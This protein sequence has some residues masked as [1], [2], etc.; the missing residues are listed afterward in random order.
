[1]SNSKPV[2]DTSTLNTPANSDSTAFFVNETPADR[3]ATDE[4]NSDASDSLGST[5]STSL[6][7]RMKSCFNCFNY[8]ETDD[9]SLGESTPLLPTAPLR[10]ET[11]QPPASCFSRFTR[12]ISSA[13]SQVKNYLTS[14]TFPHIPELA[15][16]QW[17]LS[18]ALTVQEILPA[19]LFYNI[20]LGYSVLNA[21]S[22]FYQGINL[23][24]NAVILA[25]KIASLATVATNFL[26]DLTA[27]T[28][29]EDAVFAIR[30][31]QN[32]FKGKWSAPQNFSGSW[33]APTF[34]ALTGLILAFQQLG[35]A[36]L[37]S[38]DGIA[39]Q[40][41]L[42]SWDID[43]SEGTQSTL[44]T[45]ATV[46]F[47]IVG[48]LY[49]N[50]FVGKNV[51]SHVEALINYLSW[52]GSKLSSPIDSLKYLKNHPFSIPDRLARYITALFDLIC[53]N[54][55]RTAATMYSIYTLNDS[56]VVNL[57]KD[58]TTLLMLLAAISTVIATLMQRSLR[59]LNSVSPDK[60]P[61]PEWTGWKNFLSDFLFNKESLYNILR[62]LP[63]AMIPL[64]TDAINPAIPAITAAFIAS[65]NL[66][67]SYCTTTKR[68]NLIVMSSFSDTTDLKKYNLPI[69]ELAYVI[70]S[71]GMFRVRS[72]GN[73]YH[74]DKLHLTDNGLQEIEQ[75]LTVS[76][77]KNK[78]ESPNSDLT[79]V[80][81]QL[82]SNEV[83]AL[84][85]IIQ[86]NT[87]QAATHN[88][89]QVAS[90]RAPQQSLRASQRRPINGSVRSDTFQG[91][92]A[93][94]NAVRTELDRE[95]AVAP[96]QVSEEPL[97]EST[98]PLLSS[99]KP[100][101]SRRSTTS[102]RS[103]RSYRGGSSRRE[104]EPEIGTELEYVEIAATSH[105]PLADQFTIQMGDENTHEPTDTTTTPFAGAVPLAQASPTLTVA[106]NL[107]PAPPENVIKKQGVLFSELM[108][109]YATEAI[110]KFLTT[111]NVGSRIAKSIALF[112]FI[113]TL[114]L[115]AL[116]AMFGLTI[117]LTAWQINIVWAIVAAAVAKNDFFTYGP[118]IRESILCIIAKMGLSDSRNSPVK[119]AEGSFATWFTNSR[120]VLA[121]CSIFTPYQAWS[122]E[123][124]AAKL[125]ARTESPQQQRDEEED[126]CCKRL[127]L[128][129][130]NIV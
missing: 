111:L 33:K 106:P 97:P 70:S 92:A 56:G 55:Y 69:N 42:N 87:D 28:P 13:A 113:Q 79:L 16:W 11:V 107:F 44:T 49:Y 27:V 112:E 45:A 22:A 63:I 98:T 24:G 125:N 105:S 93:E 71:E 122:P 15:R 34:F 108:E 32:L 17:W 130:V 10:D 5:Q 3:Q 129:N 102:H 51:P 65:C 6:W 123:D 85:R 43:M 57:G 26:V 76:A 72:N 91:R 54:I 7:N 52:L 103:V 128:C 82:T 18:A 41:L 124:V 19:E 31:I 90:L 74:I 48:T 78:L 73:G 35:F 66:Y 95:T 86:N 99:K 39:L 126:R 119:S 37:G 81:R 118:N 47:T 14:P 100:N 109:S 62:V 12:Y 64:T 50:M 36:G 8:D 58:I 20:F 59:Q 116:P 88:Y 84:E 115:T 83:T 60:H 101:A 2:F 94:E 68:N 114:V 40:D 53:N 80:E 77:L 96:H 9:D 127:I 38:T 25:T 61:T 23:H 30:T 121:F 1:M 4:Q 67:A 21:V 104:E 75:E 117:P 110:E 89:N 46:Y 120:P 29:A